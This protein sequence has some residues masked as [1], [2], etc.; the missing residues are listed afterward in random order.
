MA[1]TESMGLN[2]SDVEGP[3]LGEHVYLGIT[4]DPVWNKK[5]KIR[6]T[7]KSTGRK[8]DYNFTMRTRT[9]VRIEDL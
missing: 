4:D 7:S 5:F 2:N 9:P 8:I 6:V 3:E 1:D